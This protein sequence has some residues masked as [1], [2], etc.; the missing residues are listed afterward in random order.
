M[1]GGLMLAL[2]N[3]PIDIAR[4][5]QSIRSLMCYISETPSTTTSNYHESYSYLNFGDPLQHET[6]MDKRSFLAYSHTF[7]Q[8]CNVDDYLTYCLKLEKNTGQ[9]TLT[10]AGPNSIYNYETIAY[11]FTKT[12]LD[13]NELNYIQISADSQRVPIRNLIVC[14][15]PLADLHPLFEKNFH[16]TSISP[17]RSSAHSSSK[18]ASNDDKS[19]GV[20][21]KARHAIGGLFSSDVDQKKLNPCRDS[22][23]C[24]RQTSDDHCNKYSHPCRYSELCRNKD[25]EPHLI[26]EPHEVETC[27]LDKSCKFLDDPYH[28]AK[29]RHTGL[30]DFLIPCRDQTLCHNRSLDHRMKYSHGEKID[31]I[32]TTAV[33]KPRKLFYSI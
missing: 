24:L 3:E 5:S 28:R 27:S 12:N 15:K 7:H 14:F 20:F 32:T 11:K 29:Y 21:S 25:N 23:N 22:I 4:N 30:P 10:H 18:A 26:H 33:G 1:Y 31:R 6:I 8:G 9:V 13:L 2:S 19:P 17:S 16:R